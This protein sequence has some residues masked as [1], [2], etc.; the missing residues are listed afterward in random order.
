MTDKHVHTPAGH[1]HAVVWIDHHEA[2]IFRFDGEVSENTH[3]IIK[4][5]KSPQHLHHGMKSVGGG[6]PP[7]NHE[8]L[9]QIALD[10]GDA[11]AILIVG[12]SGAKHELYRRI[13]D[14]H[15]ALLSHIMGVETLDHPGDGALLAHAAKSFRAAER[16]GLP[17][18][19]G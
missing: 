8:Y 11:R 2:R 7:A 12:P 1:I 5:H 15:K 19:P 10:I 17:Y 4:D 18:S 14:H 13:Q 16:M 3:H 9:D 6:H